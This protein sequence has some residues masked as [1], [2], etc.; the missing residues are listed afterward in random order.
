MPLA[1]LEFGFFRPAPDA[2]TFGLR[3]A[4]EAAE[5]KPFLAAGFVTDEM[6]GQLRALADAIGGM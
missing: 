1:H 4:V 2:R 5:G 6:P 3:S